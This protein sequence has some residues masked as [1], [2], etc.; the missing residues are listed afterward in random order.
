MRSKKE[1]MH[2]IDDD[3]DTNYVS[4]NTT[5]NIRKLADELGISLYTEKG[6]HKSTKRLYNDILKMNKIVKID[7]S[8]EEVGE[9]PVNSTI[10]NPIYTENE[11]KNK[12]RDELIIIAQLLN[13]V[14]IEGKLI[15]YVNKTLLIQNILKKTMSIAEDIVVVEDDIVVEEPILIIKYDKESLLKKTKNQLLEICTEYHILKWK[16]KSIKSYNK[17]DIT[18]AILDYFV[19][20]E[21]GEPIH[22]HE[23]IPIIQEKEMCDPLLGKDCSGNLICNIDEIPNVCISPEIVEKKVIEGLIETWEYNGKKIV[24]SKNAIETLK[25]IVNKNMGGF[26][27]TKEQPEQPIVEVP[28]KP[29][30]RTSKETQC[31]VCTYINK[32]DLTE[33]IICTSDLTESEVEGIIP[34]EGTEIDETL[35]NLPEGTEISDMRT[36]EDILND[37]QKSN[38]I[39]IN[40]LEDLD[41]VTKKV[42]KCLGILN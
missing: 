11:L 42:F 17:P 1:E 4:N 14:R 29:K 38:D 35:D 34:L 10:K 16:N 9:D 15:S 40:N 23:P 6:E 32:P 2:N 20:L 37:I 7:G 13:I 27:E 22:I 18:D 28:I 19:T 31:K 39:D 41:E 26:E 25:M 5:E 33:C 3:S 21:L 24:G 30:K 8:D 36:I 12:K